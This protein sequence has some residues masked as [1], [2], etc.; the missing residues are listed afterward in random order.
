MISIDN[1][2][3][4]M[5]FKQKWLRAFTGVLS[6]WLIAGCASVK[7][8]PIEPVQI[9]P[10]APVVQPTRAPVVGL[11]LGGGAARGFAH[12]GVIQ[13]L[14]E[15]GMKVDL[16]AGTSAGSVVA[17]QYASGMNASQLQQ[18]ALDMDEAM[19]SDWTIP[20]F[21]R[22]LLRGEAL[23]RYVN[24][25]VNQQTLEQLSIPVGV[26]A[27]NLGTGQGVLFRRGDT[28]TAVRASSA[29]P[30]MFSPVSIGGN[31][32]VDGG[33]VAPVPVEGV[34]SMGA[35]LVIAVDISSVPQDSTGTDV[36]RTLLRTFTIMGQSINHHALKD[37]DVVVRPNLA[38]MGSADFTSR[39]QAIEAGRVAMQRAM[40]RL[41][42]LMQDK[43]VPLR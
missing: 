5:I 15:N 2:I 40:P 20:L 37:A 3:Q 9:E 18:A 10:P 22:G 29:V 26:L 12:V 17:V 32:F 39:Q 36:L 34:R 19:L 23:A 11:A 16:L 30:G 38:G 28:G 25:Q 1:P 42:Q 8:V 33:L 21:G 7:P 27:T 6:V 14:E 43:R 31:N 24:Q 4:M 35:E 13:V 41:Q